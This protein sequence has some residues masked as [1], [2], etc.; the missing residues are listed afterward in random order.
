[1]IMSHDMVVPWRPPTGPPL[2]TERTS[3]PA[4]SKVRKGSEA[5]VV[6]QFEFLSAL[7][8]NDGDW[9]PRVE[10]VQELLASLFVGKLHLEMELG[11]NWII[12]F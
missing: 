1:M 6:S 7:R 8:A 9:R 5:A 10:R 12:S 3:G 11:P 2:P 4:G